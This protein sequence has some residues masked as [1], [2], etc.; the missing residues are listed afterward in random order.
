MSRDVLKLICPA[1]AACAACA[2]LQRLETRLSREK[3][4]DQTLLTVGCRASPVR[5]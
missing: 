1:C 2:A 3:Y 4:W 5:H